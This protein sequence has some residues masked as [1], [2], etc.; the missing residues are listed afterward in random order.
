MDDLF[1][2]LLYTYFALAPITLGVLLLISAP[3]G[4]HNREGWGP[5]VPVRVG[6]L[7]MEIPTILVFAGVF[8][9]G[10][11][12]MG[13]APLVM[14]GM[15]YSHYVYRTFLFPRR[16]KTKGKQMPLLI[17]G[18]AFVIQSLNATLQAY[19]LTSMG[20]YPA[21]WLLDPRFVIGAVVFV[22]GMRINRQSDNILI[23]LRPPGSQE[24]RIPR[25]G[26][27]RYVSAPNYLGE[28]LEWIGWAIATWSLPGLAF[29][30]YT[31]ANLLPRALTNHRWYQEKFPDYPSERHALIPGIL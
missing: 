15:W 12:R 7:I 23:S 25:G 4:R 18:I 14:A 11:Q 30:L 31:V 21:S 22:L 2:I 17:A 19:W 26:M 29:A 6:W 9:L 24:Y 1:E 8:M 3:Y 28:I 10:E 27:F 20:D 16:L 13:L 5:Q